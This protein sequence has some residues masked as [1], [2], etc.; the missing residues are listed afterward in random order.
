MDSRLDQPNIESKRLVMAKE[1]H[2]SELRP[3]GALK[4]FASYFEKISYSR[5]KSEAFLDFIDYAVLML[6]INKE[7]ADFAK[8]ESKYKTKEEH[9]L[10]YQ[11]FELMAIAST[12]FNDA[13][14]DLFMELVSHGNNGQFFTPMDISDMMAIMS[15]S[16]QEVEDGQSVCDPACGSGRTL[17]SAAKINRNLKFYASDI[18]I[19]CVKMT[20]INFVL[21]SMVG[22]IVHMNALTLEHWRTYSVRK[23]LDPKSNHFLPY[24]YESA[25]NPFLV[26]RLAEASGNIKD[27]VNVEPEPIELRVGKKGQFFLF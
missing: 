5:S 15:F 7:P 1:K 26:K 19:T 13:L 21:N 8:L 4:R 9:I 10:F 23:I 11:M 18:D 25:H 22:E 24:Y 12:N 3:G 27:N 17:L 2:N 20:L 16:G 14:G 6:N